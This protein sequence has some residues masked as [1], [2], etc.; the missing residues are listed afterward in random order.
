LVP[1]D[2]GIWIIVIAILAVLAGCAAA[3]AQ[4][5]SWQSYRQ[6][7]ETRY[8][9]TDGSGGQWTGSSYKQGFMTF[10]RRHRAARLAPPVLC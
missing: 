10:F 2:I 9:G 7:F 1:G 5:S 6:G 3:H 4:P 8:Q